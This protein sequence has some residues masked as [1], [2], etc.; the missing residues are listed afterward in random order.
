MYS[1]NQVFCFACGELCILTY[2][3]NTFFFRFFELVAAA[4]DKKNS[5]FWPILAI[6]F[7]LCS[8]HQSKKSEKNCYCKSTSKHLIYRKNLSGPDFPLK[9]R[10]F[11]SYFIFF[12]VRFCT[13]RYQKNLLEYLSSRS[14]CLFF[15]DFFHVRVARKKNILRKN[16]LRAR[17]GQG[18]GGGGMR[19]DTISKNFLFYICTWIYGHFSV[20]G[21]VKF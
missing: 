11:F 8:G 20:F 5:K 10:A 4:Y 3:N 9:T 17:S 12:E 15:S 18:G 14:T 13:F 21:L 1:K 2:F 6:F 16:R 7:S 19:S